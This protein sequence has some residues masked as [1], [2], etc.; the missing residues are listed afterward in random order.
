[1]RAFYL[2]RQAAC[3]ALW[4][5]LFVQILCG[6][7]AVAAPNNGDVADTQYRTGTREFAAGR[8]AKALAAFQASHE[9]EPSPNTRFRIAQSQLLLGKIASAFLNFRRAAEEAAGRLRAT[10]EKR[11]ELT[12]RAAILEAAAIEPKV[13]HLVV[14]VP[15]Q[16]PDGF[17]VSIDD[18]PLPRAAWGVSIE[19]D[20]G[21]HRIVAEAPRLRRYQTS[22]DLPAGGQQRVELPLQRIA[23]ASLALL[24]RSKPIGLAAYLDDQP[25]ALE[26]LEIRHELDVGLH[27]VRVTAPG[28]APFG[29]SAELAD[30]EQRTV[31]VRLNQN[32]G[33]PRWSFYTVTASA[34]AAAA[35]S[36]HGSITAPSETIGLTGSVKT[37]AIMQS[38]GST[39]T[40]RVSSTRS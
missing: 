31:Q 18:V 33:P 1:M 10:N 23:T 3:Y 17:S 29:W 19:I 27:R 34:I 30:G 9:L 39:L 15:A 37:L 12:R 24:F 16:V 4:A 6:T 13:P 28:Y 22:I 25:L 35:R 7:A 26:Q 36:A 5:I 2:R 20:P 40:T 21:P 11:F 38:Y 8:Y 14:A 32:S